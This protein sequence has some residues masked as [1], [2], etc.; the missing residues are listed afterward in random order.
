M[1]QLD[2]V[3]GIEQATSLIE[4]IIDDIF[5]IDQ[6]THTFFLGERNKISLEN[7]QA[8]ETRKTGMKEPRDSLD[9][10]NQKR[11]LLMYD[12]DKH[13]KLLKIIKSIAYTKGWFR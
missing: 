4:D 11:L 6:E 2:I 1:E 10:R 7:K 12:L 13:R 8:K 5:I 9:E 3:I